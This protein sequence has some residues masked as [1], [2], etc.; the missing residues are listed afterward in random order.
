MGSA[1]VGSSEDPWKVQ[2]LWRLWWTA[3]FPASLFLLVAFVILAMGTRINFRTGAIEVYGLAKFKVP[4]FPETGGNKVQIL[5]EMHY[6]PSY[7]SQEGPRLLPPPDSV[8][9]TGRELRYVTLEEYKPLTI[10]GH[11]VQTY[12]PAQAQGLFTINC[13]VCHGPTLKGDQEPDESKWGGI[14]RFMKAGKR[15][16][17]PA[18]L[19]SE[20]TRS[21]TDGELF[22]FISSGGRQ[23]LTATERGKQSASPMPEFLRLLSEEERWMLVMYL[24]AQQGPR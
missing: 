20:A 21:S 8:P 19:T 16:P 4:A 7:K 3:L 14:I 13:M 15:G 10:P 2:S 1:P 9:V 23:G 17:F 11:V 24:R 22:G 6:Q 5:T 18:D 12:D